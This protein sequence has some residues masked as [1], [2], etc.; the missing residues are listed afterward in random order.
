M[1]TSNVVKRWLT[2]TLTVGLLMI[3]SSPAWA[4]MPWEQQKPK[5]PWM[6]KTLSPDKRADLVE[7]QMTLDEKISL[8]HG[9]GWA[10]LFSL[11]APGG[12]QPATRSLGNAGFIPGIP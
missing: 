6:D 1:K 2:V 12:D 11:F 4:Q 9:G 8:L 3:C 5:G 10:E 7:A